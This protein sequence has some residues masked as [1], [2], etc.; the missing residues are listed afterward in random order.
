MTTSTN[1][2]ILLL[3]DEDALRR[4]IATY[5]EDSGYRVF[6][7][8]NGQ[9][10]LTVLQREQIDLVFTDLLMPVMGGLEFITE[11]SRVA[12]QIPVIVISGIGVI[13]DAVEA[14]RRGAWEYV[15]KPIHDL[16][17]LEHL[18]RRALETTCLRL[19]V[20]G[21]KQKLL[22]GAIQHPEVFAAILTQSPAML[23]LFRYLEVVA[24]TCQ[25]VLITGE[26]GTGKELF[27]RAIHA[28]SG[29]SGRMVTVNLAGLDD[30][31]FADTL[32]GHARGAF[33]GADRS[34]EGLLV[35]A[36]G[37]TMVLDEIGDLSETSQ[38]KLLR[39]LQEG[40]YYPLGTDFPA[41][42]DARFVL[43]TH[44]N[45]KDMVRNGSFRQ[46][47]YYRL[48][49]HQV[50]IPPLRCRRE[51]LPILVRHFLHEAA[52]ALQKMVP[53]PPPELFSYLGAYPFPGNVRELQ[54]MV[55]DAV[56]RHTRG[57]L[58]LTSF[59]SA[60]G[61]P[62]EL[63]QTASPGAT[64]VIIRDATGERIPTLKE[65]EKSLI[66][67]ALKMANGNQGLAASYLGI[68]R[69]ALNKRLARQ[70]QTAD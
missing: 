59:H 20:E 13:N 46:D 4:G 66:A 28:A 14:L 56:A 3:E 54:A 32:F 26:T 61:A 37:G 15:V 5:F 1:P 50:Q 19:E 27:C 62:A 10:E 70:R 11:M 25:P 30:Q 69:S 43:A 7:A 24:Q 35:Q 60:I 29:R 57:V 31:M 63:P 55:F 39:L 6:C 18:A 8:A 67:Q 22:N 33:T 64:G 68:Q 21:L 44:R 65:A 16:T 53:T 45:L 42:T 34:R 23:S 38:I 49:T 51:D 48:A 12:P 58:S 36:A 17:A 47:L 41:R 52:Q 2:T 9:E 40:E